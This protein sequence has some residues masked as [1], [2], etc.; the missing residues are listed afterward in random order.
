MESPPS[1]LTGNSSY[2]LRN[3]GRTMRDSPARRRP[4]NAPSPDEVDLGAAGRH[5]QNPP[6]S[7]LAEPKEGTVYSS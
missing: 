2:R 1:E 7:R 4:R 5:C 6:L 3:R